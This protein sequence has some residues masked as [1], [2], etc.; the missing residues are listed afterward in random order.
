MQCNALCSKICE[1]KESAGYDDCAFPDF[2]SLRERIY[3]AVSWCF[4]SVFVDKRIDQLWNQGTA[5]VLC[6][7]AATQRALEEQR[8]HLK[9]S[10]AQ[11]NQL[12]QKLALC[13]KEEEFIMLAQ[14]KD[15]V[16]SQVRKHDGTIEKLLEDAQ[17]NLKSKEAEL[18]FVREEMLK[19]TKA[20]NS[21]EKEILKDV[22]EKEDPLRIQVAGLAN[23]A[24]EI[25]SEIQKIMS[26]YDEYYY[27]V[28]LDLEA[29]TKQVEILE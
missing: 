17:A 24:S 8:E 7:L 25:D 3:V 22:Q 29:K 26:D 16:A 19:L 28:R 21:V 23:L 13:Q 10:E 6:T 5:R 2:F 9:A 12:S 27:Q 11:G 15:S 18:E 1:Q 20:L 4:P 14:A